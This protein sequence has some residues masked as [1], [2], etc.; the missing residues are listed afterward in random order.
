MNAALATLRPN[1]RRALEI[2]AEAGGAVLVTA[3]PEKTERE[4]VFGLEIPGHPVFKRLERAGL[5]FY[6]EETPLDLPGDPLDGFT[7]TPEIYITD[8]GRAAL[9]ASEGETHDGTY[10]AAA[11]R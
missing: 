7:F 1:E 8:Q 6:T 3:V 2:L 11:L 10:R 9:A 5:C 4:I